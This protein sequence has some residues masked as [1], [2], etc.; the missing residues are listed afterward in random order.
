VLRDTPGPPRF[1]LPLN[2]ISV[3]VIHFYGVRFVVLLRFLRFWC[4]IADGVYGRGM[5]YGG[6][7][8]YHIICPVDFWKHGQECGMERW[9]SHEIDRRIVGPWK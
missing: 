2:Y 7:E 8:V 6:N 5:E 1:E 3:D 9:S 4:C